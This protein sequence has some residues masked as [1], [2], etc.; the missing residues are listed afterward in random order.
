VC[1]FC[2][3]T[4]CG[5]PQFF[6][7]PFSVWYNE[8]KLVPE[9]V[10]QQI[11]PNSTKLTI[12]LKNRGG[13]IGK[14]EVFVNGRLAVPDARDAKLRQNP[15]IPVNQTVTLTVDLAGANFIKGQDN[16]IRVYASNYLKEIG[17]GNIKS[18]GAEIVWRNSGKEELK[19]P[20]HYAIVGGV[21]DYAGERL[22]LRFAAKKA[23]DFA[24]A[25]KLGGQRL[26]CPREKP[27]CVDKVQVTT[28]STSRNAGTI[29]P[30]KENF[31]KAFTDIARLATP[32]DILV[33]YLAGHGVSFGQGTDTY[34]FLTQDA[35]S[36]SPEDLT[37]TNQTV[38][39]SSEEL[40]N[41]L[42]LEEWKPGQKGIRAL[43]QVLILD[44]CAA[45][46]AAEQLAQTAK[47]ELTS[48]QIRAME[49][50]KDKANVFILMGSAA[51]APSC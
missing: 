5:L 12:T 8:F 15:D 24:N 16:K 26:F 47:G 36:A 29:A 19:L 9:I 13:G 27:V 11:E 10:S 7:Q 18:R 42:T 34:F 51:D 28:L 1:R 31:R 35:N 22:D 6:R 37:K 46:K 33:L 41:W 40:S 17:K 30:T 45:G 32:D 2:A 43:K 39:I 21:S 14:T 4:S 38:A 20:T 50:L 49:F 25:L 3:L 44:T 23:E 48:D